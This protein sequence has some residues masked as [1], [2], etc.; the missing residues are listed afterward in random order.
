MKEETGL[1]QC[2][3]FYPVSLF[4]RKYGKISFVGKC[5]YPIEQKAASTIVLCSLAINSYQPS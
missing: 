2:F 1:Q 3:C 4:V 5:L